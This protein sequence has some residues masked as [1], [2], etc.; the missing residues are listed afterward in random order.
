MFDGNAVNV[1]TGASGT[2][3]ACDAAVA[4]AGPV[5]KALIPETLYV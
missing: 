5:P 4:E 2:P 1:K 3:P